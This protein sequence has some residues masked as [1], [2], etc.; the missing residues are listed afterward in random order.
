MKREVSLVEEAVALFL[1]LVMLLAYA[2]GALTAAVLVAGFLDAVIAS[3]AEWDPDW[4]ILAR[5]IGISAGSLLLAL[6][7]H[8]LGRQR[9][10]LDDDRDEA[11]TVYDP[12]AV[13]RAVKK[14]AVEV[15]GKTDGIPEGDWGPVKEGQ[16]PPGPRWG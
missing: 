14:A 3:I 5:Y 16:R 7:I 2:V 9:G 6:S 15:L 12:A 11:S 1:G 8:I 13:K 10:W 4:P